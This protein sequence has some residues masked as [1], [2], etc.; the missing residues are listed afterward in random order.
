MRRLSAPSHS[1]GGSPNFHL[2]YRAG[3]DRRTEVS[4]RTITR[5]FGLSIC[6]SLTA[7]TLAQAQTQYTISVV[8]DETTQ[9]DLAMIASSLLTAIDGQAPR[10]LRKLAAGAA[11]E[12]GILAQ[13]R[14]D[15]N[16]VLTLDDG[17][18]AGL[19]EG[20]SITITQGCDPTEGGCP[21]AKI[22]CESR[23]GCR[24]RPLAIVVT[25]GNGCS[26]FIDFSQQPP[27]IK[28]HC[29]DAIK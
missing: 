3:F 29:L 22:I 24:G 5:A 25:T 8:A 6:I 14:I 16:G 28:S 19:I 17:T 4:M 18:P 1:L 26:R 2:L 9:G 10:S 23:E 27:T 15:D 7:A 21:G 11:G 12:L 13:Q 20:D